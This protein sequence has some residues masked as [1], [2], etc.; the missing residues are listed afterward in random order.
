M[1]E[2]EENL[3]YTAAFFD[4]TGKIL[5]DPT[6]GIAL[7]FQAEHIDAMKRIQGALGEGKIWCRRLGVDRCFFLQISSELDVM[8]ALEDMLPYLL[9]KKSLAWALYKSLRT[10]Y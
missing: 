7:L 8:F 9:V 2:K 6:K 3:A 10:R 4:A 1:T 5:I